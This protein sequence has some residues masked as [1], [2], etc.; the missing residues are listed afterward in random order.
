[1]EKTLNIT[2]GI[3]ILIVLASCGLS[4][5]IGLNEQASVK[6]ADKLPENPL[7]L[8]VITSSIRHMDSTMASLYGNETAFGYAIHHSDNQYPA[9]SILYEVTWLQQADEQWA[10][11]NIPKQIHSIE[12][13][14]YTATGRAIY[15]LYKGSPLK[16]V[17]AV[18]EASRVAAI[19]KQR[20][21]VSP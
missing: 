4:T 7:I 14:E 15:T 12:R 10:G 18:D 5:G 21:A 3:F 1:M 8:P 13:L 17:T 11:A 9:G 19:S 16:K 6:T 2:I 20:I